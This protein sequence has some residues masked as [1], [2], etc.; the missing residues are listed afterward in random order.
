MRELCKLNHKS[1]MKKQVGLTYVELLV[2]VLISVIL[3]AI[4]IQAYLI[5]KRIFQTIQGMATIQENARIA[6]YM[7]GHDIR[8]SGY[9]DCVQQVLPG[10]ES[11]KFEPESNLQIGELPRRITVLRVPGTDVVATQAID[12][13]IERVKSAVDSRITLFGKNPYKEG[14]VLFI[15]NCLNG[16]VVKLKSLQDNKRVTTT[17]K[18]RAKY[19]E[20][21]EIAHLQHAYYFIGNTGRYTFDKHAVLS[22]YRLDLTAPYTMPIE[23][24]EGVENMHVTFAAANAE[25][26]K[27]A[28]ITDWSS[29]KRVRIVLLLNSLS[30]IFD[31]PQVYKFDGMQYIANDRWMHKEWFMVFNVNGINNE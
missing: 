17:V 23:I 29:I 11:I 28:E 3:C 16:E 8:N 30:N 12:S 20:D 6:Y 5:Q 14:D 22:L 10:Y 19:K 31:A 15:Y 13:S 2:S 1:L 4:I 24:I 9:K 7:L 18:L 21:A 25:F 26:K 27:A